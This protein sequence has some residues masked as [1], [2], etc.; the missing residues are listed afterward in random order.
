MGIAVREG[1]AEG[2]KKCGVQNAECG[3]KKRLGIKGEEGEF[4]ARSSERGEENLRF[5]I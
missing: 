5:E 2:E 4:E 1:R 3:I